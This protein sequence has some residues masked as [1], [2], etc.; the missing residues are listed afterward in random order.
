MADALLYKALGDAVKIRRK[1]LKLTQA[2]LAARVNM[3]RASVANIERGHQ[4]TL[5]HQV[6]DLADALQ[7]KVALLLPTPPR[8]LSP[9]EFGVSISKGDSVSDKQRAFI[10]DLIGAAIASSAAS[11]AGQ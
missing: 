11:K 8:P 2:D 5:L 3:S 7:I 9:D 6:Y 4:K 1:E 10:N